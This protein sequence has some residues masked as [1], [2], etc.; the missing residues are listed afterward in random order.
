MERLVKKGLIEDSQWLDNL[1][2]YRAYDAILNRILSYWE[3][4][5]SFQE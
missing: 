3:P 4:K 2:K 1:F 5:F